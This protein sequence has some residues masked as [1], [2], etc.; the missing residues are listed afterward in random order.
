MANVLAFVLACGLLYSAAAS[1]AT[2]GGGE[3][4][5]GKWK[6]DS[7]VFKP[8][9]KIAGKA[10]AAVP[11]SAKK[12]VQKATHFLENFHTPGCTWHMMV[13]ASKLYK[14]REV[15]LV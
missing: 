11:D 12:E 1:E 10:S 6:P 7:S 15:C 9:S 2:L 8:F 13:D 14:S 5:K 3:V 4:M